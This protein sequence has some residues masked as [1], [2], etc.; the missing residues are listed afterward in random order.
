MFD[1]LTA[2][3]TARL[4][5]AFL[6]SLNS[7]ERKEYLSNARDI[8][9][10]IDTLQKFIAQGVAITL[11]G[12]SLRILAKRLRN[13]QW[14]QKMRAAQLVSLP[15]ASGDPS[16]ELPKHRVWVAVIAPPPPLVIVNNEERDVYHIRRSFQDIPIPGTWNLCMGQW[17]FLELFAHPTPQ[18][19][20]S[21]IQWTH[22]WKL[23][24]S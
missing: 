16:K 6:V 2:Y 19:S 22:L 1:R 5:R 14:Y 17:W 9:P 4:C 3:E 21:I 20:R 18:L 7:R 10:E 12:T 8:F 15:R 23:I 11:M 24:G 13:L